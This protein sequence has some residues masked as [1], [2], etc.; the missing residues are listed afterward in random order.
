[1]KWLR[2]SLLSVAGLAAVG[3]LLAA[4]YYYKGYYR[5]AGRHG[6]ATIWFHA[7][8]EESGRLAQK[9]LALKNLLVDGGFNPGIVFLVDM[10]LPSGRNRF[11]VYDLSKDSILQAGLVA[12]GCGSSNFSFSPSF[13]NAE[14]SNCSAIGR[15][16]IG[17][18]YM[19][20]FGRSYLLYGL[21]ST[22]DHAL[23]RHIVLHSY[24]CVP[25]YETD[26]YPICNS[27]G[28]AMVAP[29]FLKR[30][31]PVI[32]RSSQPILLWIFH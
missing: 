29:G 11:F 16:R 12:H 10:R 27:Q 32:D 26:P 25:E 9:A 3:L 19:G 21:D 18:P 7:D 5:K 13:S 15:Y 6:A 23:G 14:G 8:V 17:R 1:M 30:L 22:N 2:K 20:H 28:C 31:E 4:H 24:G